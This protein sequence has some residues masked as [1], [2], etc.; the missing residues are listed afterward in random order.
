MGIIGSMKELLTSDRLDELKEYTGSSLIKRMDESRNFFTVLA[1]KT[2]FLTF[3]WLDQRK[4]SVYAGPSDFIVATDSQAVG[5]CF[6]NVDTEGDGVLQFHEFLLELTANDVYKL[7]SLENLIIS[8]EDNLLMEK[9]PS[10]NGIKD[11]IKVRKDLLKAKR[12]YEQMEFLTDELR[13]VDPSFAFIDK[14]FDRLLEFVLHLQEYIESVR[15]AYQAQI[16]IEQNN[17]MKIFTVVTSIF[18]PLTLIAGW[19]GMNLELPEYDWDYSYPFVAGL[20]AGLVAVL[21]VVFKRKKW[22]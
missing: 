5:E 10:K 14:K 22:F 15:E 13:A 19:Y 18:L 2:Y 20:S 16:D 12:Y 8:L 11:I 3:H 7:E 4:V 1:D 9:S 21:L 6:R 17:L